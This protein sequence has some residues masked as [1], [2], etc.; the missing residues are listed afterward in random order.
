GQAR[1]PFHKGV[2]GG[3][4]ADHRLQVGRLVQGGQPLYPGQV[5]RPHG[6]DGA[7]APGLGRH[8]LD[9]V[10]SVAP[11]VPIGNEFPVGI[12]PATDVHVHDGVTVGGEKT[13]RGLN[14]IA[15]L[16]VGGPDQDGRNRRL[17]SGAIHIRGKGDSVP[18]RHP[19]IPL[20]RDIPCSGS[21]SAH[22]DTPLQIFPIPLRQNRIATNPFPVFRPDPSSAKPGFRIPGDWPA[23]SIVVYWK[24]SNFRGHTAPLPWKRRRKGCCSPIKSTS[25]APSPCC[26]SFWASARCIS[27][28]CGRPSTPSFSSWD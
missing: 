4:D 3:D 13:G 17:R 18:H 21:L 26:L 24:R 20:Y 8:P 5:R 2:R 10:V 6:A 19:D 9:A 1:R 14:L 22:T 7:A 11:L 15:G 23:E 16:A 25:F 27:A 28:S 12:A